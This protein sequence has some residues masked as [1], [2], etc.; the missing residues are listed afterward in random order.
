MAGCTRGS[1]TRTR[2]TQLEA[3]I[4]TPESTMSGSDVAGVAAPAPA[5][6]QKPERSFAVGNLG[7]HSMVYGIGILLTKAIAFLMLPIYTRFLTPAD[8]GV[9]QLVTMI[10]EVVTIVAGSRIAY[11]IFHFY[12][13]AAD[14]DG[15]RAVLSTA[16]VLLTLMYGF[17]GALAVVLAPWMAG[18]VFGPGPEYVGYVQLAA[19]S[20]A[21]EG[22]IL[23]PTAL[24]QLRNRSTQFVLVSVGRVV[25]Q[26]ALNLVLLV[27][28]D[29]GVRGVL[30]ASLFTNVLIGVVLGLWLVFQVG[31]RM[32]AATAR[33]FLRF[34][35]PLV[36]MQ[37]A[38]FVFTFGDRYFLNRAADAAAVGLYGLAYQFGFLVATVGFTPFQRVW[39]PQRFAVA[40]SP[41]RDAIYA[42]VFVLLNV[43][44]V[45]AAFGI[46]LFAGDVLRII[47]TEPFHAAARYVP[48]IAAAYVFH[49]WS[50]FLNIGIYISEKTEYYTLANWAAA[51]VA[52]VG[53][54]VLIPRWHAWGAAYATLGSLAVRTWLTYVMSQR[55]WPVKYNWS[56][57]VRM[58]A[59]ATLVVGAAT[60][61]PRLHL[62]TSIA[63]H[64][65]LFALYVALI[66]LLAVPSADRAA[67]IGFVR[68]RRGLG[69]VAARAG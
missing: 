68:R 37:I 46:A 17:A 18:L 64:A 47:A 56:P 40:R 52:V 26:V 10:L 15:R 48:I 32:R 12:H 34:G 11:G 2:E 53:F 44:L 6:D 5:P 43:G 1:C 57:V 45:T 9:L 35:L 58:F 55:L 21:F 28:L 29:M 22:L 41:D 16:M 59:F 24:F 13:K 54:V 20:M 27:W 23:V 42:R 25:V 3:V 62:A 8:Y 36:A 65:L 7:K 4:S 67:M 30:L 14:E 31:V 49:C 38:T 50:S 69:G 51:V 33:S 63:L 61:I 60:F 19:A 39:D 66:W